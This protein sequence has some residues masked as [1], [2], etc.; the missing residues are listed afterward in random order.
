MKGTVLVIVLCI[1]AIFVFSGC[2]KVQELQCTDKIEKVLVENKNAGASFKIKCPAGCT[3]GTVWGTDTYTT[4]SAVCT[5]AIHSG[6]IAADKGG[7]VTVNVVAS[8]PKYQGSE[9]NGVT[10]R[11]WPNSWGDK[12]FTVSK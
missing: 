7:V 2:K 10:T 1:A 8:L 5:A 3:A 4:D 11:D 12:A 6:V 9:K